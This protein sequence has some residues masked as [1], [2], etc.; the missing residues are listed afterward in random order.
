MN[1][2]ILD[3]DIL[4]HFQKGHAVV[5]RRA[6]A[7]APAQLAV[8]IISAEE[9]LIGWYTKVRQAKS[10][11]QLAIAYER[12]TEAIRFLATVQLVSYSVAAIRRYEQ[13]RN[14]L[15]RL[16]KND[17]RIAAIAL[18]GGDTVATAN[19]RDF[20]QTPGLMVEDWSQ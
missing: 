15:R 7:L 9:E 1:L 6:R 13:L 3:T 12:M 16:S 11:D 10:A 20:Q 17:L 14:S 5:T 18:E 19:I 4:T 2:Y 8:S